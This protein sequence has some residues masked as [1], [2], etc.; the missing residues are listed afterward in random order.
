M[1]L[2]DGGTLLAPRDGGSYAHVD[3]DA[4]VQVGGRSDRLLWRVRTAD[5]W[6][7]PAHGATQTLE[8]AAVVHTS[9]D[10]PGGSVVHRCAVGV[11]GGTPVAVIEIEN[12]SDYAV[13]TGFE[14]AQTGIAQAVPTTSET[15]ISLDGVPLAYFDSPPRPTQ[16]ADDPTVVFALPHTA[17][18]TVTM[19][20][21][22]LAKSHGEFE[23]VAVPSPSD[24]N[25]GWARHLDAAFRVEVGD[26]DIEAAIRPLQRSLVSG[27]VADTDRWKWAVALCESGYASEVDTNLDLLADEAPAN[28]IFA[29]GRWAELGGDLVQAERILEPLARSAMTLRR[30]DHQVIVPMGWSVGMLAGAVRAAQAI[31]QPDVADEIAGLTELVVRRSPLATIADVRADLVT[32]SSTHT[33][34]E[35]HHTGTTAHVLRAI[36]HLMVDESGTTVDLLASLPLAWRGRPIDAH[37]LHIAAGVLSY[38]LR[39]HGPRPALLWELDRRSEARFELQVPSISKTW[40]SIEDVGE[41]LLP[42]PEW[43]SGS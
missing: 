43:P 42:D 9:I 25:R 27:P 36:R 17:T 35:G 40:T 22:P 39:W 26:E 34:P 24:I 5:G 33:F 7:E 16:E 28:L 2:P 3:K 14:V 15:A 13:A 19:P 6:I 30:V 31:E 4:G 37:N 41:D 1:S 32:A 12:R 11:A 10:V 29:V 18:V 8:G 20:L 21:A 23:T 38:G